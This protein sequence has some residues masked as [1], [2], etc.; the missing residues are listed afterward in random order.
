MNN[1]LYSILYSLSI[2]AL[3]ILIGVLS[4]YFLNTS[5]YGEFSIFLLYVT[6]LGLFASFGYGTSNN[7]IFSRIDKDL[8]YKKFFFIKSLKNI[9]ILYFVISVIFGFYSIFFDIRNAYL[10]I[11]SIGFI[12]FVLLFE[13]VLF[14]LKQYRI[15]FILGALSFLVFV[16]LYLVWGKENLYYSIVSYCLAKFFSFIIYAYI[17]FKETIAIKLSEKNLSFYLSLYKNDIRNITIPFF[18]TTLLA[19]PIFAINLFYI[20]NFFG[21]L[22]FAY[23]NWAYQIYLITTFVP[24]ALTPLIISKF[25]ERKDGNKSEILKIILLVLLFQACIAL[26]FYLIL[27]YILL[28]AGIDFLENS[29]KITEIFLL[30]TLFFSYNS[31]LMSYWP[32]I[33]KG[34]IQL[35]SQ[36]IFIFTLT[37]GVFVLAGSLGVISFPIS[38]LLGF[39]I[40]TIYQTHS[41]LSIK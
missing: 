21:K 9:G 25:S 31:I 24:I 1:T 34:K 13:G 8:E 38:I 32:A 40:Q 4:V 3:P 20:E 7:I 29:K 41:F 22:D 36:I 17:I 6:S 19:G 27:D 30:C 10:Y 2:K 23:L 39:F 33:G 5:E 28:F 14:G 35:Y 18:L 11:A 37:I 15:L 12:S 16:I 26:I